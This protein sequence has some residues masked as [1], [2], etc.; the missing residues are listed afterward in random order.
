MDNHHHREALEDIVGFYYSME[1]NTKSEFQEDFE[2]TIARLTSMRSLRESFDN[3]N[4]SIGR[5]VLSTPPAPAPASL[6]EYQRSP[7][8]EQLSPIARFTNVPPYA[9]NG[10]TYE[11]PS[12]QGNPNHDPD[13]PA[14]HRHSNYEPDHS[15]SSWMEATPLYSTKTR[16]PDPNHNIFQCLPVMVIVH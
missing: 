15:D 6:F 11:S 5:E 4:A 7:I 14:P 2:L 16:H 8:V 12:F 13:Y 3:F 9:R 10:P 1:N